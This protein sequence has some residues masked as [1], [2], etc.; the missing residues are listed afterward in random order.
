MATPDAETLTLILVCS[1]SVGIFVI[2]WIATS[3]MAP[4]TAADRV[5]PGRRRLNTWG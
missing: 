4:P 3:G 5:G 2:V 1:I